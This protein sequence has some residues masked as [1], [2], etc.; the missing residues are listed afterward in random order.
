MKF[1]LV[2][3][4]WNKKAAPAKQ[5]YSKIYQINLARSL[6]CNGQALGV[7]PA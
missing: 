2:I 1:L 7:S 3:K 4:F 5:D 6:N